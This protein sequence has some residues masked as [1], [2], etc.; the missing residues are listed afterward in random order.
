MKKVKGYKCFNKDFTCN[1]FQ[2]KLGKKFKHDGE[3]ELCK[4]GFHFCKQIRDVFNYYGFDK[5]N[6]VCEIEASGT[7]LSDGD[8]SVC[9]EIKIIKELSWSEVLEL[10]NLGKNNIGY[11]NSGNDNAGNRNSGNDNAGSYNAGHS[12]AGSY[13]AGHGNA[14]NRN[15]G[16]LNAG[17]GNA[18]HGNA[19]SYN[20]G[21]YNVGLFNSKQGKIRLFN[22][23][24]SVSWDDARI[25][26]VLEHLP[27]FQE[28]VS[29]DNMTDTEKNAHAYAKITGGYFRYLKYKD[30][31]LKF[32]GNSQD[33]V[34]QAFLNLPN[35]DAKVFEEITGIKIKK[36]KIRF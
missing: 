29:F 5:N 35:F 6:H 19:G 24:S 22:K 9:S 26:A 16:N 25:Q 8:K 12:N 11:G 18:G 27:S 30:A 17:H 10:S 15:V 13:N 3:I 32:W 33:S 7:I 1:N 34:K 4:S 20:A 23:E 36:R 31:W 14:G 21:S 2:F 28:Y